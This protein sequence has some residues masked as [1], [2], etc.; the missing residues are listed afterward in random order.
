MYV[1]LSKSFSRDRI[2]DSFPLRFLRRGAL[3]EECV[4][5]VLS[6]FFGGKVEVKPT[7]A[8]LLPAIMNKATSYVS[9]GSS[10]K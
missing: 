6:G 7:V 9:G 10:K 2:S 1:S 3:G 5:E 8:P 4:R